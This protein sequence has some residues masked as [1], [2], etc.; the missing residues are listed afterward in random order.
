MS[1][2]PPPVFALNAHARYACRHSGACCSA[3]WAIPV[4][5]PQRAVLR[6]DLLLPMANGACE[7]HDGDAHRCRV[8]RD[9]GEALLPR[10]CYHFPR[11]ALIDDRGVFVSLSHF[12]PTAAEMLVTTGDPLRTVVNPPAFPGERDYDGLDGRGAWPP[13]VKA[14]LLFD[15]DGYT[16]WEQH[17]LTT[18][19]TRGETVG[20][21]LRHL[22]A[23]AE[24]L[25]GWTPDDGSLADFVARLAR[26][27]WPADDARAA[28]WR[29]R[30]FRDL[31]TYE[32]LLDCVPAG[33]ERPRLTA[34]DREAWATS[35]RPLP[36]DVFRRYVGARAFGT[37]AA[38]EAFGIRT[39]IAELVVAECVLGVEAVRARQHAADGAVGQAIAA[40]RAADWLLVHLVDRTALIAWLGEVEA[41]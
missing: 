32:R 38:Y 27:D 17:V 28:W 29:Y 11:R 3:G 22:A 41:D 23:D 37:W 9:F 35:P 12:C 25:R 14:D 13:L 26:R 36:A 18:L 4:E 34:A 40:V 10:S 24:C 31:D 16:Q 15:L 2:T 20:G 30:A 5:A 1:S 19:S 7:F 33:L 6:R 8:Q 21:A 39:L